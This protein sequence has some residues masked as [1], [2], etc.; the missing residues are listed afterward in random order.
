[1]CPLSALIV[2][3]LELPRLV[4]IRDN[5][6]ARIRG[7]EREGWLGEIEGLQSSLTH[8]EEKIAQLDAQIARKQEAV[9]LGLPTSGR[10]LLALLRL[11]NRR[12][13]RDLDRCRLRRW[14]E[15]ACRSGGD[16]AAMAC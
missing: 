7:A 13:L 4:E 5:L 12:S 3:A 9:N 10:S 16:A 6:L 2:H 1:M 14:S 8:A 15:D 11:P